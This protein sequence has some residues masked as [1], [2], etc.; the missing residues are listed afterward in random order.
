MW[1]RRIIIAAAG[2]LLVLWAG[3]WAG[4]WLRPGPADLLDGSRET[5]LA[6]PHE[7]I[8]DNQTANP[9]AAY[10]DNVPDYVVGTDWVGGKDV[11]IMVEA[12]P[13]PRD[14]EPPPKAATPPR[15]PL[16]PAPP[17]P[18][19]PPTPDY[20]SQGGDILSG[21]EGAQPEN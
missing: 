19:R 9:M 2:S 8:S 5:P 6:I 15:A 11:P 7:P 20:P 3:S 12:E 17:V 18:D 21:H 14:P 16:V 10:G 1:V 4:G 13:E